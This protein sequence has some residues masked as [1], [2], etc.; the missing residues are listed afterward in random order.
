MSKRN[1]Y[2]SLIDHFEAQTTKEYA[3]KCKKQTKAWN[4]SQN[5][6]S[7]LEDKALKNGDMQL[8][9]YHNCVRFLQ[10]KKNSILSRAER[11]EIYKNSK[12]AK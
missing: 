3:E 5:A 8:V 10:N 4:M 7:R 9:R 1:F 6:H 11:K 12:G 2:D